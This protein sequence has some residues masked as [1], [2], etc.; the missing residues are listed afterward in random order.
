MMGK[1]SCLREGC[2]YREL[3]GDECDLWP[4]CPAFLAE[5]A[6]RKE[7]ARK[8]RT[9]TLPK[10][11]EDEE[12]VVIKQFCELSKI[13][14]VHIPNEGKR[15]HATGA[16]LK[17]MGLQKGFPDL[18]IPE[19]RNGYHGLFIELKRDRT[20]HPTKEQLAWISHLN[21]KGYY[22]VV[23]YGAVAAIAEIR[24]YMGV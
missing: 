21:E 20:R 5:R 6:G 2:N 4:E 3:K 15:S 7:G 22:A 13:P 8:K 11:T 17:A 9:P 23:C 14:L 16:K 1:L 10:P 18:F 12:Q 24:A 19:A